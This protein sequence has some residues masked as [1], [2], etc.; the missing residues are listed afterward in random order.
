MTSRPQD[1]QSAP[2]R[3]VRAGLDILASEGLAGLTLRRIAA[4]AGLSHAAPA[5]HFDGLQG[6]NAA[7]AARG[8]RMLVTDLQALDRAACPQPF[9]WLAAT[10]EACL[11]FAVRHPDLFR[12]MLIVP[13]PDD[14]GLRSTIRQAHAIFLEACA[15]VTGPA[16]AEAMVIAVWAMTHGYA[17]LRL[18]RPNRPVP[19]AAMPYRAMLA[20]LLRPDAT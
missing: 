8:F 16:R 7:I 11:A 1:G 6:L 19:A 5:H 15:A 12:L 10:Q 14:A 2:D 13:L 4:Q 20:L 17:M 9:D 18:A 3:L